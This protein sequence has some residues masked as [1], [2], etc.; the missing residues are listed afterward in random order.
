MTLSASTRSWAP[1]LRSA[2]RR[3]SAAAAVWRTCEPDEGCVNNS[4]LWAFAFGVAYS[5][6]RRKRPTPCAISSSTPVSSSSVV[7]RL[8]HEAAEP[9]G[10]GR[11]WKGEGAGPTGAPR[12]GNS[13]VLLGFV[14]GG[15]AW[16]SA[17]KPLNR[18]KE[19]T[20]HA[21]SSVRP[22]EQQVE[23]TLDLLARPREYPPMRPS[24]GDSLETVLEDDPE[25]RRP[26]LSGKCTGSSERSEF[27]QRCWSWSR[28]VLLR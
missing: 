22:S 7:P 23:W 20:T 26:E 6:S 21:N 9:D 10:P 14:S 16:E 17:T 19:A 2:G 3:T 8:C 5:S 13:L 1:P 11:D 15:S 24:F 4:S 18:R 12:Q 28:I 27:E 25:R